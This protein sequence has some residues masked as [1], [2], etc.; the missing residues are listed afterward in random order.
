MNQFPELNLPAIK[1]KIQSLDT[2]LQIFDEHRKKYVILTPEEWV[3]QHILS[4]LVYHL[5]YPKSL[6]QVES[7]IKYNQLRKRPDIVALD[8]KGEPLMIVECKAA[9]VN[10][11]QSTFEQVAVYNKVIG[12][13]YLV[14]TNGMRHFCC[15]QNSKTGTSRFL[16]EIPV[17][18]DEMYFSIGVNSNPKASET[19]L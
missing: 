18:N 14:V 15:E 12:A 3:R 4:F 10:I 7:G 17:F 13:R 8:R 16:K 2:G 5:G 1:A 9:K 19:P 6:I 11:N